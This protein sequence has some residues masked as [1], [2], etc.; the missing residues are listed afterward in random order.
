M[1]HHKSTLA[2]YADQLDN[3]ERAAELANNAPDMSACKEVLLPASLTGREQVDARKD[4]MFKC[5]DMLINTIFDLYSENADDLTDEE[6]EALKPAENVVAAMYGKSF[7]DHF[8]LARTL[9]RGA[10]GAMKRGRTDEAVACL[11]AIIDKLHLMETEPP[12]GNPLVLEKQ[13]DDLRLAMHVFYTIQFEAMH[14]VEKIPKDFSSE[15]YPLFR[16]DNP[17][18]DRACRELDQLMDSDGGKLRADGLD[19][20]NKLRA[21]R[22]D[23]ST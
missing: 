15:A 17:D 2:S 5:T 12:V 7:S 4:L 22:K 23:K 19:L 3:A 16:K 20:I 11:H 21:R 1:S 8:V 10:S 9:Y 18:Y 13:Y 6:W 14:I